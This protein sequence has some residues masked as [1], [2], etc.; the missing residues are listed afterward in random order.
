MILI[1]LATAVLLAVLGAWLVMRQIG[2]GSA[3]LGAAVERLVEDLD[4]P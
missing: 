2:R 1:A 4:L 3:E